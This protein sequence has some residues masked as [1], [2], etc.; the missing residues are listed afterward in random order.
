MIASRNPEIYLNR[1]LV[2]QQLA[3][4]NYKKGDT[5]YL[6]SFFPSDDSRSSSDGGR[7]AA[8]KNLD[9]LIKY[10]AQW[11]AEERGV[12]FVVNGHGQKDEDVISCRAIFYEHDDLDKEISKELWRSLFLPEPTFQVDTGGKSIHSYWVFNDQVDPVQWKALQTDLLEYAA[13]DRSL[14]NQSR[15]M[16][17]AGASHISS[18]GAFPSVI[19][20]AGGTK[21]SFDELRAIIP[22]P[23]KEILPSV[24]PTTLGED[25]PLSE[26]LRVMD[27]DFIANGEPEG[28]RNSTGAALARNLIGTAARLQY[29]GKYFS[30]DPRQLFD[31]Y[32]A[33]CTPPID[34]KEADL[35]WKSAQSNNPT[36]TLTDDA[37][38]NCV[39]SWQRRQQRFLPSTTQN[40]VTQLKAAAEVPLRERI[41]EIISRG[42]KSS[43]EKT[44]L[45]EL[46]KQTNNQPREIDAIAQLLRQDL[47][48]EES[49][50]ERKQEVTELLS[51]KDDSLD[52][53]Q[54]L[55]EQL[56]TPIKQWCR[57]LSIPQSV[58]ITAILTT[59]STL[60]PVGTDLMIHKGM[61]FS[62]PPILFSALVGES[63]QKKSPVYRTLIKK[64]LRILQN[65]AKQRYEQ[66]LA[67]YENDLAEWEKAPKESSKPKKPGSPVY[68]FTNSTGEGIQAQAQETP[69]KAMFALVDELAGLFNSSNQYRGG[70]GSD[71]QD[72]LSYYDGTGSTVLRAGGL[73]IDVER[74]YVSIFGGIQPEV[75]KEHT[76]D[77][78][79]GD[80]HW[81]R[82]LFVNQPL[83]ASQLPD[84][85]SDVNLN[86]LLS[87]IYRRVTSLPLIQYK[88]S[89]AAFKRYQ[90]VYDELER[91][92]V[93]HPQ[94]GMRAVYS[95]LE[96]TIG[97]LALNLH[98][99]ETAVNGSVTAFVGNEISLETM[100][101]AIAL[102]D[103]YTG[104]I[105]AIHADSR[106]DKGEL[107]E[108]L[109]KIIKLA[110]SKGKLTAR[111]VVRSV[112]V[113]KT[114]A[115]A[116]DNFRELEAMGYGVLGK[117]KASW[118]FSP[119]KTTVN[120]SVNDFIDSVND[121]IDTFKQPTSSSFSQI[122]NGVN[123][124]NDFLKKTLN[125]QENGLT[126]PTVNDSTPTGLTNQTV[127][128]TVNGSVNEKNQKIIDSIDT[129][130]KIPESF[131][132][133]SLSSVNAVND[134]A[135]K[136]IDTIAEKSSNPLMD[137]SSNNTQISQVDNLVAPT[138]TDEVDP[139]D[140]QERLSSGD[141]PVSNEPEI[142]EKSKPSPSPSQELKVGDT[143]RVNLPQNRH[144][145]RLARISSIYE[146]CSSIYEKQR[147]SI[148]IQAE[149]ADC[150]NQILNL[151]IEQA[152]T[153][154]VIE[155]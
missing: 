84:A 145:D 94:Q 29:L 114:N 65:E 4:L 20:A 57:W 18:K 35:I 117:V 6:R 144:H 93:S 146:Q 142:H 123:G 2:A 88:L 150:K 51:I 68:F 90:E 82:F 14:K 64:P 58:A 154:F 72:L 125:D 67:Q 103:F 53:T 34:S 89:P 140:S 112:N 108:L 98:A 63:G 1:E 127:N 130:D 129:I 73:K 60:H 87:G 131:T 148:W 109:A 32:C 62:V 120:G 138:G 133:T 105:K 132:T 110:Q 115:Q 9:E 91:K 95:K 59:I 43:D 13:A 76:K 66:A 155:T 7:K 25:I 31:N 83:A 134:T 119:Q 30:G 12:Y 118:V 92:R 121:V 44:A 16:R 27:R 126:N 23:Q 15:V 153:A 26:C 22:T 149:I 69:D 102:A 11:Q 42:L 21:Y 41:L 79:D 10:V 56:A 75:L 104:Q 54:F 141:R 135:D 46:A 74:I 124:V 71:R 36:A 128:G 38:E 85:S 47:E 143:V 19:V 45:L 99:I 100:N 147:R 78:K 113:V 101:K 55:P 70:K 37:I 116:I 111:E 152:K 61:D 139:L 17:L 77:L 81:A 137:E 49:R 97:R 33:R 5:V 136:I 8:T 52:L 24:L 39:R 3:L 80:G 48:V 122:V 40:K 86:E 50:D 96:G 151:S 106:A 28:R 107:S